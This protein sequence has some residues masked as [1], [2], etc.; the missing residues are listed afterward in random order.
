M[1][2][3]KEAA[4]GILVIGILVLVFLGI[5]VTQRRSARNTLA[6][7]IAELGPRGGGPPETIEG[8][9]TAISAYEVQIEQHVRDAA[10]TGIYWKILATRLQDRGLHNDALDAL[11]RA[12]YYNPED[13]SLHY[14]I[15][16]SAG[17]IAKS[18]YIEQNQQSRERYYA[19]SEA[20]Y[21][22][23][24]EL[25]PRYV[26]PRYGL[27]VLYVFELDRP[28]DAIPHLLRYLEITTQDVD[29]M[30]ILARA[31]YMTGEY[32]P[33]VDLYDT[34]IDL[35]KDA[36]KRAEARNNKQFVLDTLYG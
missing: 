34:I 4:L 31:Y 28:L 12:V 36:D 27:G 5:L 8:L 11:E 20:G 6:A 17:I 33:A 2:V 16:V 15:G 1:R 9:R 3:K 13:P 25:D 22:R 24:V 30:F 35:T 32:Q 29:A 7:R 19:L 14:L 21:L 18:S 10:Q 26:R 23:A